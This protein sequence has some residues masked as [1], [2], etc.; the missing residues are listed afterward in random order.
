MSLAFIQGPGSAS[1]SHL[2]SCGRGERALTSLLA[3]SGQL[4][5]RALEG[6]NQRPGTAS[7]GEPAPASVTL[8]S[9]H[10]LRRP[11]RPPCAG[12]RETPY[13]WENGAQIYSDDAP[14]QRLVTKLWSI[15]IR[16]YQKPLKNASRS[17]W[18]REDWAAAGLRKAIA[19][20]VQR[21]WTSG[22]ALPAVRSTSRRTCSRAH[23]RY[24]RR[25]SFV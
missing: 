6:A 1:C 25:L 2:H 16:T 18:T 17:A 22:Q 20:R 7:C 9:D 13:T 15:G 23:R 21:A 3:M 11:S 8:S 19:R 12:P 24:R 14:Y 5:A 4:F 10:H